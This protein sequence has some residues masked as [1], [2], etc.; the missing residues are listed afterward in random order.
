MNELLKMNSYK[1]A[2]LVLVLLELL[3]VVINFDNLKILISYSLLPVVFMLLS[4]ELPLLGAVAIRKKTTVVFLL[5]KV[6]LF[7]FNSFTF[8]RV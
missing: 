4:M 3:I 2:I 6:A 7:A 8:Y 1:Y 5:V